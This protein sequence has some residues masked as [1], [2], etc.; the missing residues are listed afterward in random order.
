MMSRTGICVAHWAFV[1]WQ[2]HLALYNISADLS[3]PPPPPRD[4]RLTVTPLAHRRAVDGVV[5]STFAIMHQS[6]SRIHLA[7][8]ST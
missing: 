8:S 2:Y 1:I 6:P 5:S 7:S 3:A 4:N